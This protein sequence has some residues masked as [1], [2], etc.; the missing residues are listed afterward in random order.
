MKGNSGSPSGK[1]LSR[2]TAGLSALLTLSWPFLVWFSV[3]HP[4][5]RWILPLLVLVFLLRFYALSKDKRLFR[6]TG[7][8]LAGIGALL[9]LTS[10]WLQDTQWLMGYPVVVNL[11]MLGLFGGSLYS[12][13]PLVERLARLKE[14][15]LPPQAIR[16]TRKV[17]QMWCLFF[18]F[19]GSVAAWTCLAG[20]LRWWALW[21]GL[22]SYVL[23]GIVM[24]GEWLIRQRLRKR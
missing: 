7:G 23:I 16:Y 21:N 12:R 6:E 5:Q 20:N 1:I 19:N 4:H 15:D 9:C 14:P 3:T 2:L 17:T 10:L 13:M 24:G 18:V 8:L 22:M 11:V